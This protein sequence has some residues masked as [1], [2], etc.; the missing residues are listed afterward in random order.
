[1]ENREGKKFKLL[2]IKMK[3]ITIENENTYKSKRSKKS[4]F[5]FS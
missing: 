2:F 3:K 1:M 5:K 4:N